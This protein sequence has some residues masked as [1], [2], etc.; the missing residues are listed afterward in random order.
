MKLRRWLSVG[1]VL[2]LAIIA[3]SASV[4][5]E[6]FP[7]VKPEELK[8]LIESGDKT[9]VIVDVQPKGV[10]DLGHVKEAINFPWALDLKSN[11]NLPKDKTLI[12][13]CDCAHEE[14]STDVATQLKEMASMERSSAIEGRAI[15]ME[16]TVKGV[17]KL[18]SVA[19][20]STARLLAVL[21]AVAGGAFFIPALYNIRGRFA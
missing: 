5:A 12:L 6:D 9:I 3:V 16:D 18:L 14:D 2:F 20:I 8:K 7:Q 21:A 11:G 1:V 17:R 10:Y 4:F 19:A 13:Y 15:F